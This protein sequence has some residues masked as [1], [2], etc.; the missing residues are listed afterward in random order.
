M[1]LTSWKGLGEFLI[2]RLQETTGKP[3]DS[4]QGSGTAERATTAA[5]TMTVRDV[6]S[7]SNK[8]RQAK[9]TDFSR[10]LFVSGPP[11]GRRHSF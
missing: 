7:A 3:G 2:F 9:K 6:S 11:V 10:D 8:D 4:C 5:L 1:V